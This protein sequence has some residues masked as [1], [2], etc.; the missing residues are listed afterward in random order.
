MNAIWCP[1][2]RLCRWRTS[3]NI[4]QVFNHAPFGFEIVGTALVENPAEIAVVKLIR[5]RWGDGWSLGL[6][7]DALN[8]DGVPTKLDGRWYAR[9]VK[10]MLD[11][12]IYE[13]AR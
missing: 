7:A 5:E 10:N 8:E 11:S 4:R 12:D 6:I 2:E 1:K 3:A 13:C 9:T